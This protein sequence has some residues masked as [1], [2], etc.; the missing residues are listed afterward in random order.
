M[1]AGDD[2]RRVANVELFAVLLTP[3]Q[4]TVTE[5]ELANRRLQKT[6]S[7]FSVF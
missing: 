7:L 4:L 2:G 6:V 3:L 5:V 1:S